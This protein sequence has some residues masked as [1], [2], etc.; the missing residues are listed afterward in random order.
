MANC[1]GMSQS[2][3]F[4]AVEAG[5]T[6]FVCAVGDSAGNVLVEERFSTE[7]PEPTLQRAVNFFK[8]HE[9]EYGKIDHFGIG[10]FGPAGVNRSRDDYGKILA[11]PKLGWQG[12]DFVGTFQSAFP[13]ATIVFDTD[14][15]A[16]A[17]GEG[18]RGAAVGLKT[19]VYVTVG[20]GIGGGIVVNGR[21]LKGMLHPDIGHITV[22]AFDDFEGVCPFHGD[23][24]EGLASGTAISERWGKEA[25][26]LAVDH[27]AWELEA[28]YLAAMVQ[29]LTAVVSPERVILGG[30]VMEQT[31]LF[32]LVCEKF[33]K[34]TGGYWPELE[35]F[36]VPSELGN[37]AGIIGCFELAKQR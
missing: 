11:T 2:V 10:T 35:D 28:E 31:Q 9:G 5:G 20:T 25:W 30:G 17:L 8:K 18:K 15:N 3:R 37:Q 19:Y 22:P 23:C 26:E 12:A 16:A 27:P 29:T 21:P 4:G 33:A 24:L 34:N 32:S 14:V 13:A 6:K 7:T 36:I 1:C